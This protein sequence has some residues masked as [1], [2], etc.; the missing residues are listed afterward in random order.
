MMNMRCCIEM[1]N[2]IS[3]N[4]VDCIKRWGCEMVILAGPG[5]DHGRIICQ[6]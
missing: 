6:I 5:Q 4:W 3:V 1:V 2:F